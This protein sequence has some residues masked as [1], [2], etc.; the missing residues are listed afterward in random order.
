MVELVLPAASTRY[1]ALK[2]PKTFPRSSWS[3]AAS[4]QQGF[5]ELGHPDV[6][7]SPWDL[8]FGF[9]LIVF[10]A[11]VLCLAFSIFPDSLTTPSQKDGWGDGVA[12]QGL[13]FSLVARRA[14]PF[15]VAQG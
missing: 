3:T 2:L 5:G 9:C 7:P 15:H 14:A 8:H 12:L 6:C 4:T 13:V 11:L 1:L 10:L